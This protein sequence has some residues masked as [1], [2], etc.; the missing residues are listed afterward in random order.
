MSKDPLMG[1]GWPKQ[2]RKGFAE[3]CILIVL[4]R[5]EN[6]GYA[7]LGELRRID[8]LSFSES[9]LYPMLA[10]LTEE[11]L[12]KVREG[13]SERGRPRRYYQLTL[14]GRARLAGLLEYWEALRD[15]I[16]ELLSDR[17]EDGNGQDD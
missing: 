6:Y 7:I 5:R 2:M 14:I 8:A 9:T 4:R 3:L 16:G 12:L 15:G 17:S 11:G 10:K 1:D 13:P